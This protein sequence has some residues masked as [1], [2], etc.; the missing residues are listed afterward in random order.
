[1]DEIKKVEDMN[2][3]E[4]A[5][6]LVGSMVVYFILAETKPAKAIRKVAFAPANAVDSAKNWLR[7]KL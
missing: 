1:M 5:Q 2:L 7:K 4:K 6:V 3:F